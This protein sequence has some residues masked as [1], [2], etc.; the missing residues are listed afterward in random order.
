MK[1]TTIKKEHF[2]S[3]QHIKQK[4]PDAVVLLR[5]DDDYTAFKND[6][7]IIHEL[8][9]N[10]ITVLRGI[11]RTCRFPFCEIDSILHKLVKAG[12]KVALCNQLEMPEK[13]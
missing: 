4:Y 3:F 9:G 5:V 6:A 7:E 12:N 10:K 13:K 11:G 2:K 1:K 8:T